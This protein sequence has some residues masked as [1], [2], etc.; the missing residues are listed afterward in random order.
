MSEPPAPVFSEIKVF[1]KDGLRVDVR[2]TRLSGA[3]S[4]AVA[5]GPD[6]SG[7]YTVTWQVTS[8]SDAHRTSGGSS[9]WEQAPG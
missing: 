7:T 8:V 4:L 2:D 6:G 3:T 5:L 9:F 1:D